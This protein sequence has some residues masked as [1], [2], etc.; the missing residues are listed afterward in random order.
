[1]DVA[2]FCRKSRVLV[3][4]GK[5]GVGKTT[6]TAA[7]ARMAAHAGLSV[8]VVELEGKPGVPA[9]FG[10]SGSL[11]YDESHVSGVHP[12][13]G[14]GRVR[15]RRIT[16]DDAL[17]EY[18]A[19]HG[20]KRISKRLVSSGA[21]DV[22]ATAIPGIRDILV[23]GKVKSLERQAAADLILVDAP[24]TGHA[25]TFLSSA[26]GLMDAARSGPVRVQSAD[27]VELLSDPDRCQVALVTLAEEMPVNEV[28]EA[29][30]ALE[31]RIGIS[32]GP[33]IVNACLPADAALER[34]PQAAAAEVG[35]TLAEDQLAA[36]QAAAG[37]RARRFRLQEEQRARLAAELPLPQLQAP[38]L[39]SAGIGPVELDTLAE[40]LA[41]AVRRLPDNDTRSARPRV[42]HDTEGANDANDTDP[43]N[44]T[45]AANE[46]R[47]P[48]D[49]VGDRP[50]H[51][52]A[53]S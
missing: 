32:L 40:Q 13:P 21:L 31:D 35:V 39:F 34:D 46:T 8:L 3:V 19:D 11:G 45:D 41:A 14:G 30:Y 27:V 17:L 51:D 15:A 22:V 49:S 42:E 50:T 52:E 5:G 7:L 28:V 23:L 43:A 20:M 48:S 29:A 18:L 37:F 1:M 47:A 10:G 36:V 6:I 2:T 53:P 26:Q 4:A 33:V 38:F 16:P 44:D 9:A 24:A 25:M 12:L